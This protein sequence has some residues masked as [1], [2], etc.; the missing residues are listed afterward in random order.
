MDAL[1]NV[2]VVGSS[3][4]TAM[5]MVT[6]RNPMIA[7]R[8]GHVSDLSCSNQLMISNQN[9]H[10]FHPNFI[11]ALCRAQWRPHRADFFL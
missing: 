6:A 5:G 11:V 9:T 8:S 2:F 10:A 3:F 7:I 1:E 4:C